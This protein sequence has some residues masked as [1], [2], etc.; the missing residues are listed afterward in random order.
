ME[1]TLVLVK[2]DAFQRGLVGEILHRFERKGLKFAGLKMMQLNDA[3]LEEHYAHHKEKPFF[4]R[5]R[6]SMQ[7]S[8]VVAMVLEG[9]DAVSMVRLMCGETEGAKAGPGT[10][11]GDFSIVKG[12]NIVHASDSVENAEAEIK[13]FFKPEELFDYEHGQFK[14]VYSEDE[15]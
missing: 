12:A 14:H 10:I 13:R 2:P 5:L 9:K 11:R 7:I 8:P 1:K 4:P 15:R 3:L 6:R